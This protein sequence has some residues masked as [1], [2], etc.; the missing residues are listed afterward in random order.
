MTIQGDGNVECTIESLD[1]CTGEATANNRKGKLIFFYEWELTLNWK[2]V[3]NNSKIF[4]KG[5]VSIPNLSEENELNDV[6]ITVTIDESNEESET[7][8]QF[9]YNIGREKIRQLLGIYIKELKEEYSK[10]LILPNKNS[11][12]G[13]INAIK[14]QK[15]DNRCNYNT[16]SKA[17]ATAGSTLGCKIEVRTLTIEDEFQ[18]SANDLYNVLTKSDM[19]TS[20]TRAPA[21]V[22]ASRG[23]E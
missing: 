2:G 16:S 3:L 20:F 15:N 13:E 6:E 17:T 5:K 22:E 14:N 19:V 18:C 4:H 9:M 11:E 23:G 21:K 7:I 12:K 8:K 10:N 1:K